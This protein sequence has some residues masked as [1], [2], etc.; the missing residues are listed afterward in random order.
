MNWYQ[1]FQA[2]LVMFFII[3]IIILRRP[4]LWPSGQSWLQI[5]TSGFDSRS[6]QVFWEVASLE[7]GP[8]SLVNTTEELLGRNSS[9][10]GLE[11]RG[12]GS[13]DPLRW[14]RDILYPQK[15][16]LTSPTNGGRSVGIVSS[17]AQATE[18]VYYYAEIHLSQPL[19]NIL[20]FVSCSYEQSIVLGHRYILMKW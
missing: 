1:N 16:A 19:P 2:F 8:L 7:R 13:G 20:R 4:P 18:F 14:P 9:G 10:S 15:L 3:I 11:S 5:Q 6:Y 12:Y 17:R